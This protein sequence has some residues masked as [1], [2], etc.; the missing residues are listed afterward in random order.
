MIRKVHI[1]SLAVLCSLL[2]LFDKNAGLPRSA[3]KF[4]NAS[5]AFKPAGVAPQFRPKKLAIK[6]SEICSTAGWSFGKLGNRK[7]M[8]GRMALVAEVMT[9]ETF[10][11]SI[12]PVHSVK[13]PAVVIQREMA[14]PAAERAALLTAETLPVTVPNKIPMKS[15]PAHK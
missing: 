12:S 11:T 13:T 8:T 5:M 3:S 2:E 15:I 14:S 7:V 4:A 9:P 6:F 10:A 1:S